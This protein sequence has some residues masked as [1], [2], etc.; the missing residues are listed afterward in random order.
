GAWGACS[1]RPFSFGG[2]R[3]GALDAFDPTVVEVR[4]TLFYEKQHPSKFSPFF[5]SSAAG[6]PN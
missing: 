5:L 6:N 2:E 1:R 4:N 3:S